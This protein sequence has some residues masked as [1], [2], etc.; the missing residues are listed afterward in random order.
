MRWHCDGE[1]LKVAYNLAGGCRRA[2][3]KLHC[4]LSL[5]RGCVG[6]RVLCSKVAV[7][8][9]QHSIAAASHV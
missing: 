1:V 6:E 2:A 7:T 8:P 4:S 9:S 5:L 3:H